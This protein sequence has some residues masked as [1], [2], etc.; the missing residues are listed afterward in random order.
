MKNKITG[1]EWLLIIVTVAAFAAAVI[2]V[3][4]F[5]PII[6]AEL[7]ALQAALSL[8]FVIVSRSGSQKELPANPEGPSQRELAKELEELKRDL[9]QAKASKSALSAIVAETTAQ[10]EELEKKL[11]AAKNTAKAVEKQVV[12]TRNRLFDD[13]YLQ[14]EYPIDLVEMTRETIND[15]RRY[16]EQ[17][18]VRINL[19]S[20]SEQISFKA[21]RDLMKIMLKNIIDNS[22]KYMLRAGNIQI[23][24][25]DTGDDIFIILKDDGMG[26]GSNELPHI[27]EINFQG[28]NRVSGNGL[29]LTQAKD[30]VNAYYGEIFAK[31][32]PGGGMGIYIQLPKA[33][34]KAFEDSTLVLDAGEGVN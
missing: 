12:V 32:T 29:G 13:K 10:K 15:M 23:T 28:T 8:M 2:G 27:F 3:F 9:A 4:Y 20:T 26:I 21:N 18:N 19:L 11:E 17:A 1:K 33:E 34:R 22:I 14:A 5:P 24:L 16:A 30:I 25:S 6:T 7:F 31:S